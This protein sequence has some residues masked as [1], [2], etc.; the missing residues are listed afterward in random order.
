MSAYLYPE[1]K[2]KAAYKKAIKEGVIITACKNTPGGSV[3]VSDEII[4]FE[5]PHYPKSHTYYG[6]AT[7]KGGRVTKVT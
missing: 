1:M 4:G 3:P 5:G 6:T 7:V 2:S